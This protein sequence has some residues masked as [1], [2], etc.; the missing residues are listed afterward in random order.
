M[1]ERSKDKDE[2]GTDGNLL[3]KGLVGNGYDGIAVDVDVNVNVNVGV[4]SDLVDF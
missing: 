3:D 2:T 4:L 1:C